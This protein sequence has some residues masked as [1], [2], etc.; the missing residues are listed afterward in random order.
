M[1]T[2]QDTAGRQYTA[3]VTLATAIA[4]KKQHGI[5][6][7][8]LANGELLARLDDDPE[9]LVNVLWLVVEPSA[10]AY[11]L[12]ADK[13][14]E[15]LGGDTLATAV[16]ALLQAIV[17]F[18]RPSARKPLQSILDKSREVQEL[19]GQKVVAALAA[20]TPEQMLTSLTGAGGSPASQDAAILSPAP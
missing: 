6:L 8:D 9:L 10:K 20:I 1:Q 2:F 18:S 15:A 3:E 7:Q 12:T 4:L 19:A 11:D 16:D 14:G 5:V 17:N 13:F